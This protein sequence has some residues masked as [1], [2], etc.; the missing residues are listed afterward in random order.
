MSGEPLGVYDN[1][2]CVFELRQ[3]KEFVSRIISCL[4]ELRAVKE[5]IRIIVKF[6]L[7]WRAVRSLLG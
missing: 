7:K 1:C 2:N 4:I 5:F 6:L 3:V